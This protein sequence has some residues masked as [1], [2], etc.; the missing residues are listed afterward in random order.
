MPTPGTLP[1][2]LPAG[3]GNPAEATQ[4]TAWV[5]QQPWYQDWMKQNGVAEGE[6][7]QVKLNDNQ[8]ASLMATM[9]KNG[10]GLNSKFD[11]VDENGM[12]AEE[13]HKLKKV[14]I[15][16]AIAGLTLT[17]FG[18]AG[19]GP[20]AGA[21]GGGAAA[22]GGGTAAATAA[23]GVL[24]S[25]VI[26]T[27]MMAPIVGGTGMAALGAGGTAAALGGAAGTLGTIGTALSTG[28]KIASLVG[29][30]QKIGSALSSSNTD[31][32]G[33]P[34]AAP[35]SSADADRAQ[36]LTNN[37]YLGAPIDQNG[38]TADAN[39]MRN[40]M[41]ASIISRM[42]PN[43]APRMITMRG[44]AAPLEQTN[45]NPTA[46]GVDFA[47]QFQD[48][49]SKRMANGQPLT[50]SGVPAA[51]QEELDAQKAALNSTGATGSTGAASTAVKVGNAIQQG[52]KYAQLG[53][54]IYDVAKGWF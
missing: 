2:G 43:A 31:A 49:M 46:S 48:Q 27:G 54:G 16:A 42:D 4:A 52:T 53:K 38:T 15:A 18:A 13:H 39:S 17:G 21:L 41:R 24:P 1:N 47:K 45:I 26:G 7:Q 28:Q 5:R 9:L 25:T 32:A 33:N 35:Q 8:R 34:I 3:I 37:R 40:M 50:L 22:A 36:A 14:A 19:I 6:N 12:I 10:I 20:L 29:S 23:G 44:G 11:S 30:A 51:S